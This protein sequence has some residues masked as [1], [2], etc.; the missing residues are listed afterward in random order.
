MGE[1][2]AR[3]AAPGGVKRRDAFI[4]YSQRKNAA[5]AK[6]LQRGLER[7]AV[8]RFRPMRMSVFRDVTSLPANH[9]L[10]QSIQRELARSRYFILLASPEAAAS[11][12]VAREVDYWLRERDT[13]HLLIAVADGG[14]RW[15][16]ETGDFDWEQT[17]CLPRSLAGH[18][19]S[20]PLWVDL[21]EIGQRSQ[22]SLRYVPFRAAVATL[23]A[24]LHGRPKEELEHDDFRQLRFVKRLS[25]SGVALLLA[26][27][28]LAVY[29]F[30]DAGRQRDAA[31]AQAR[32]SASQ[33]LAA[34][35]GQLLATSPNQAAQYALYADATRSTP[36]SRRALAQAVTAAPHATRRLRADAD[37][38]TDMEGASEPAETDVVIS[39]DGTTAAYRS[40]FDRAQGVR[41]YDV[42]SA[43]QSRVLRTDGRPKALSRD[44]R[45]LA[46]EAHLN[47]VE[48][49]D[50][51]T[52]TRLG[53]MTTGHTKYLPHAAHGLHAFALSPDGRWAAASHYTP[54]SEAFVVV[55]NASTGRETGRLRVS[56]TRVG[57]GFSADGSRMTLVDSGRQEV[58]RFLTGPARWEPARSLPGMTEAPA[59]AL[60]HSE[61]LLFD[62]ARKALTRTSE[63]AEVWDLVERRRIARRSLSPYENLK[64]AD[65]AGTFV[66][67]GQD[68]TVRL[69][70]T[71]LR[72]GTTLGRLV[73][74]ASTVAVSAD[75]TRVAAGSYGGELTLFTTEARRGQRVVLD[76]RAFTPGDL[77]SDGRLAVRRT[78]GR[79]EFWDPHTGRRLGAIP[80]A[81]PSVNEEDTAYTLS[82]DKRYVGMKTWEGSE[83]GDR[84]RFD[85]WDLRTGRRTDCGLP[86]G[87][88]DGVFAFLPGDR[89]VVGRT[90][91]AVELVDTR[92]CTRTP[93]LPVEAYGTLALSGDRRTVVHVEGGD[94]DAWRWDGDTGFEHVAHTTVPVDS[95]LVNVRVDHD[96]R[97]AAVSGTES[98]VYVVRLDSGRQVRATGYLPSMADDMAFSRDGRLV[99]Q[100][101]RTASSQG[102]RV[103]DADSGDQLDVWTTDPPAASA[104]S[105]TGVQIVPGPADDILVLGPDL[106]IVRRTAG[107]EAWRDLLCGLVSQPLP[108]AER[109]RYLKDLDV[110]APC[111]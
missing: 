82:E 4:S 33:A 87:S 98:H 93:V 101:F 62:G 2:E 55:W 20:A 73:R 8:S 78:E 14:I 45:V 21:R 70:D 49:W 22:W 99:F 56:D 57:L 34:R 84:R 72:P 100:G 106:K 107:V 67:G 103:L 16:D 40:A 5:L 27:L 85:I 36:E 64:V 108:A 39:A 24:P 102:V 58:R 23:A 17:T 59:E 18:F 54:D 69:H 43:R 95:G 35:S 111:G 66:M 109:D 81:N 25:W 74:P 86:L 37:S 26:L 110:D 92:A 47:R 28:V 29:G 1:V 79:T 6:Q 52:G 61:I 104:A 65:G 19:S 13:E 12:W 105:R 9:D 89:Y 88:V 63:R 10:W 91:D 48:L 71:D 77:T 15:D 41:V 80:Y 68:G 11:P 96:G 38:V 50:T 83:E 76:G 97:Q 3:A 60:R 94:V 75:G 53:T 51:R 90:S 31:V 46:L 7:L 32:T 44:G 30:F 42:R